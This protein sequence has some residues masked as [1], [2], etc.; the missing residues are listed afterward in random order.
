MAG[1]ATGVSRQPK[2]GGATLQ[3]RSAV[4]HE[5]PLKT[6]LEAHWK[7]KIYTYLT[8]VDS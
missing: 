4:L 1:G 5:L 6:E 3:H 2:F 7:G 8:P